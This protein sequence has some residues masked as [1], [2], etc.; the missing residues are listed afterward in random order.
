MDAIAN[1][2]IGDPLER[3]VFDHRH[4]RLSQ[5]CFRIEEMERNLAS[6]L[7]IA[8]LADLGR[9]DSLM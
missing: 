7:S 2:V 3:T 4:K 5:L 8:A 6:A 9:Q 1:Q